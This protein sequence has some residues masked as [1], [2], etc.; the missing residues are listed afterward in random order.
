MAVSPERP[1]ALRRRGSDAAAASSVAVAG[2]RGNATPER[3]TK[4]QKI[5]KE[6]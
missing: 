2:A 1:T 6:C 3:R 5:P 4:R